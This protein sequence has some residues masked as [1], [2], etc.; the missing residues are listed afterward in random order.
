MKKPSLEKQ[1]KTKAPPKTNKKT[2]KTISMTLNFLVKL[3]YNME[4][5]NKFYCFLW[6]PYF[7]QF[8]CFDT[9]YS[10]YSTEYGVKWFGLEI[11]FQIQNSP[12]DIFCCCCL[13]Y[14]LGQNLQ[15]YPR[16]ALNSW[17]LIQSSRDCSHTWPRPAPMDTLEHY[18]YHTMSKN[19]SL[20]LYK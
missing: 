20:F 13:V 19:R 10:I 4:L 16:L 6:N 3:N 1:T 14:F 17:S 18:C 8:F 2:L 5:R 11:R 12:M 7:F 9:E 15:M